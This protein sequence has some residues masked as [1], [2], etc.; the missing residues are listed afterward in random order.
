MTRP[1]PEDRPEP[2]PEAA[3]S[4]IQVLGR[5]EMVDVDDLLLDSRNPRIA[6]LQTVGSEVDQDDLLVLLWENMAVDELALS[7]AANGYFANEEMYA[8]PGPGTKWIVVEGN[9]RLAAVKLLR[10]P[11]LADRLGIKGVPDISPEA[12]ATLERLPVVK[13]GS[14]SDAWHYLGFKHVNGPKTWGSYSKAQ[15]IDYV[16]SSLDVPLDKIA[17]TIGDQHSTVKRLYRGIRVVIQA[18]EA[19]VWSRDRRTKKNFAFSHLYTGLNYPGIQS[20]LGISPERFDLKYPVP[21]SRL[22]Q[23]KELAT[24]LWGDTAKS[25]EPVI[26]SQNPDLVILAE[27]LESDRGVA[28]LRQELGLDSALDLARGSK[29]NFHDA[30]VVALNG[31]REAQGFFVGGYDGDRQILALLGEIAEEGRDLHQRALKWVPAESPIGGKG[32]ATDT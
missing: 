12:L 29:R 26:R 6:E 7:I 10:S 4:E 28:A 18:E 17:K 8:E 1:M 19:G 32:G 21:V 22:E 14:R 11:D 20:F 24:W 2:T 23:L 13:L 3:T 9:R 16:H 15:Y 31:L 30:L 25:L 27:V 5:P